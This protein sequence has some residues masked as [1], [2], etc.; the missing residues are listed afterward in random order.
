M[1]NTCYI[2]I[3][4]VGSRAAIAKAEEG[5]KAIYQEIWDDEISKGN[6]RD[7]TERQ[8]RYE[9]RQLPPRKHYSL[10]Y[11]WNPP[12]KDLEVVAANNPEVI[13]AVAYDEFGIGFRGQVFFSD[14]RMVAIHEGPF[15][16]DGHELYDQTAPLPDFTGFLDYLVYTRKWQ[17]KED[18]FNE[19]KQSRPGE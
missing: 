7:C 19:A 13:V 16:P 4:V 17:G 1:S 5:I 8:E 10:C 15:G 11:P 2:D 3:I 6:I 9:W 18:A 12:S 14:G